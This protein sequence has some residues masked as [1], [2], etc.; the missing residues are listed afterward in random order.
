MMGRGDRKVFDWLEAQSL[1]HEIRFYRAYL[2]TSKVITGID[3]VKV[4][5][6]AIE[7]AQAFKPMSKEA[8]RFR[9]KRNLA[10]TYAR[11]MRILQKVTKETK[12]MDSVMG[13][14]LHN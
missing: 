13:R 4:P 3:D 2:P 8:G 6:Q 7:A 9:S 12:P 1:S 11:G 5:D 10:K 14:A